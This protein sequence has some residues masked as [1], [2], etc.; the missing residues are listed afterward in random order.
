MQPRQGMIET[1]STFVQFDADRFSFWVTDSKLN[2]SIKKCLEQYPQQTSDKF[3]VLYW[4]KIWEIE[5]SPLAVGHISAYLQEVCFWVA[6]KIAV[7]FTSQFSVADCFQIAISCIHKIL[8]NFNPEYSTN[9]KSYAEYAFERFLKDSLR[10]GKEADICT[11]WALL[12]K[13]S[14]KRLINALENAGFNSQ[15]INSY[16]LAWECF[17]ELYSSDS[18]SI[19]QLGK[20]DT[21]TWQ[22]ITQLYNRQSLSQVT[23][24]TLEKWLS[25]CAKA[26]RDFLYPKFVS[27]DAPIHGQESG[28]LLDT[29]PTNLPASLLTEI[30]AHEE[31]TTRQTQ[32]AQ[33]N[34]VLID[35]LARLDIQ[36]QKLLQIY[37][38]QKLTQQQIAEQ[39]EIKQYSVSRRLTS[40][41]RSLLTTLTEW[42]QIHLHISPTSVVVDAVSQSLE[43]WLN[44]YYRTA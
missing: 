29:L 24:E 19:R 16:A 44:N 22:A 37:Y 13:I 34:Q 26:V 3:W 42:S 40:I 11:D 21:A 9:L 35:A 30:I 2:R 1:F 33:L 32:Q 12:H 23:P 14:R 10:L 27:V 38:Q 6:R 4:Y 7:N 17:K 28:N 5:S 20:P 36:S 31:A 15:I 25:T 43:E 18:Q 41:K 39:L 8:K